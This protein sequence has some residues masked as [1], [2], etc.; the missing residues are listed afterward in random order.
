MGARGALRLPFS[1]TGWA[2][3]VELAGLGATCMYRR[4][5][6][7]RWR[8]GYV[9]RRGHAFT[10]PLSVW[11]CMHSQGHQCDD[12][13]PTD[14]GLIWA[15]GMVC[16]A[17][18]TEGFGHGMVAW[19][20]SAAQARHSAL[21]CASSADRGTGPVTGK[22][23]RRSDSLQCVMCCMRSG[24][25]RGACVCGSVKAVDDRL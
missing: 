17:S 11:R 15:P 2:V 10:G 6:A 12:A 20:A 4:V 23:A 18:N 24:E 8:K 1:M 16:T 5:C 25:W 3:R 7:A 21:R 13:A 19:Y 22:P 9:S 14:L